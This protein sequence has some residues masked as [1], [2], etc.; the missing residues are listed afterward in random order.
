ME[1]PRRAERK[2]GGVVERPRRAERK[3][4]GVVERPRRAER[5]L[6]GRT[7]AGPLTKQR[8]HRA[9][10]LPLPLPPEAGPGQGGTA[11]TGGGLQRAAAFES[12]TSTRGSA[13]ERR[14]LPP[15]A[16]PR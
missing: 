3:L 5:K 8:P 15:F 9:G 1:R 16:A 13:V 2:L 11:L 7:L 12:G 10:A 4:G 14:K 6:G